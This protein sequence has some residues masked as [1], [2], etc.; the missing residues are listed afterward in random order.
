MNDP[1]SRVPR[2]VVGISR[3]RASWWALAWAAG[4]A[5][6]RGA[7]LLLVHVYRPPLLPPAEVNPRYPAPGTLADPDADCVAAGKRLIDM[8]V[9]EAV[10]GVPRDITVDAAVVPGRTA[11]ELTALAR[12]GDV[13]VLGS[14]YRGRLRRRAPGSV[15]RACCRRA[16]SL[17]MI[18]PE[19]SPRTLA[20]ALPDDTRARR[21]RWLPHREARV[22]S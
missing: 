11:A 22:T 14:R 18:V 8:A 3:S 2:L 5:R 16:G 4:E 9:A 17:V 13:L 21:R 20:D 15:A 10:G 12:G 1:K 6:R 7:T 19:P